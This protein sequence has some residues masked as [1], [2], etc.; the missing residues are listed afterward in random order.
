MSVSS[1]DTSSSDEQVIN[2]PVATSVISKSKSE[3]LYEA[4]DHSIKILF[5]ICRGLKDDDG[6]LVFDLRD[7]PWNS[8][9]LKKRVTKWR[10]NAHALKEHVLWRWNNFGTPS[11]EEPKGPRPKQWLVPKLFDWLD[12]HPIEEPSDVH[13][14]R[15][16]VLKE[17]DLAQKCI[18]KEANENDSLQ[19]AWSGK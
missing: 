19:W 12:N 13:F 8:A 2:L 14:I 1:V 6:N 3:L 4:S 11:T 17:K 10:P 7:V 5:L 18:D 15:S 9:T 16:K